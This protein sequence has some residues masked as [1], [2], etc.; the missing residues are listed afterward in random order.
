MALTTLKNCDLSER[1]QQREWL[2]LPQPEQ[3]T[4][5]GGHGIVVPKLELITT[6]LIDDVEQH[7]SPRSS[8]DVVELPPVA[9]TCM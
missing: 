8:D 1:R 5:V 4:S 6:P 2:L 7:Q 9:T 3:M